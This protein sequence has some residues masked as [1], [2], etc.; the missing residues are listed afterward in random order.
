[1]AE[2]SWLCQVGVNCLPGY[3][4]EWFVNLALLINED[5]MG[6]GY[7]NITIFSLFR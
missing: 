1:M 6:N 3:V 7:I 5:Y 2:M 4:K